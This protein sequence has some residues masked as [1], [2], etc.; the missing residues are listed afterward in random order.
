MT[1]LIKEGTVKLGGQI[2]IVTNGGSWIGRGIALQFAK[3]GTDVI[4][5]GRRLSLLE[6]TFEEIKELGRHSLCFQTDVSLKTDVANRIQKVMT[7][8]GRVALLVNNAG[9]L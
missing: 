3:T 7:E 4:V 2:A 6:K 1:K 8:F 9:M 5:A